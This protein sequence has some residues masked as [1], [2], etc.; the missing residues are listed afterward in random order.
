MIYLHKINDATYP[1]LLE[2][3]VRG[4]PNLEANVLAAITAGDRTFHPS[5]ARWTIKPVALDS[6]LN[7][8]LTERTQVQFS[9]PPQNGMQ[10][11]YRW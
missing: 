10:W 9:I 4:F 8:A 5:L 6:L 11:P 3:D 1:Y 2:F 7:A